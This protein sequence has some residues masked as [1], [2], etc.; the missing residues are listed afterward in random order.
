MTTVITKNYIEGFHSYPDAPLNVEFLKYRHRHVF[1]IECRFWV[2]HNN[3]QIEIFT[4]QSWIERYFKEKYGSPA[5][6]KEMSCEMIAEELIK[7]FD[8]KDNCVYVKV[9]EDGQGG[10]IVQR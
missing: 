6:F 4:M 3:R 7:V 2:S 10:A 8:V 9:Q 1:H 5:E